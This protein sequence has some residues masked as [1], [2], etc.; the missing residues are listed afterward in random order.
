MGSIRMQTELPGRVADALRASLD[1]DV[2]LTAGSRWRLRTVHHGDVFRTSGVIRE[3]DLVRWS[4]RFCG[5]VPLR[6]TTLITSVVPDDGN[7][8]AT[9]VDEMV[10]GVFRKY[11]HAHS[12]RPGRDGSSNGTG[13]IASSTTTMDDDV[14]WTTPFGPI[15]VLAD[16]LV[17]RRVLL[18]LLRDRNEEIRRRLLAGTS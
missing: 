8:G 17:V 13:A 12:F 18:R 6:H 4:V 2:E 11:R 9:F 15:G 1:L 10:S 16:R 7:G 14:S 5:V 3:R